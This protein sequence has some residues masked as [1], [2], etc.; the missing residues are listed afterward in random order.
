[1]GD[2]LVQSGKQGAAL[3]KHVEKEMVKDMKEEEELVKKDIQAGMT[4]DD[5]KPEADEEDGKP[6]EDP[7]KE[8]LEGF[9]GIF[10][11]Y[12]QEF[13][14]K[15]LKLFQGGHPVFD[16]LKALQAKIDSAEPPSEEEVTEELDKIDL[17]SVG[18]GL[19][20]GRVLPVNDI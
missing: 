14:D 11:D 7:L 2:H 18:A 4:L 5:L 1:M 20:A 19:G 16:Q 6:P 12:H 13:G 10:D 9:W 3:E 8:L 17:S 15:T